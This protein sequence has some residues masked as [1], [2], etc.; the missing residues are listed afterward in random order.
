VAEGGGIGKAGPAAFPRRRPVPPAFLKRAREAELEKLW[1]R[2]RRPAT[3]PP[4]RMRWT[5]IDRSSMRK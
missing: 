1:R 4:C 3:M 5:V 2:I